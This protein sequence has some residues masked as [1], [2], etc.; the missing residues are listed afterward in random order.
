MVDA[1]TVKELR[2]LSGAGMMDCKK[3]LIET[4]GDIA[5]AVEFLREKGLASAAKKSGREAREGVVESY[6]HGGGRI[7][8]LVEVNC[9]TDFVARTPE[10]KEL[11][12]EL[13]MQVAAMNPS[14]LSREDVP[15]EVVDKERSILVA[16]AREEGKPDK[17]LDKVVEG[18]LE[19]FFQQACLLEQPYMRDGSKT[20]QALIKESIAQLGENIIVRRFVRFETGRAD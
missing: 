3:A 12:H 6:V 13:A 10:F 11:A 7:G 2:E 16:Q 17:V 19:K 14:Y 18:R 8:V 20:V 1:K 9:E 15:Q 5:K 4:N